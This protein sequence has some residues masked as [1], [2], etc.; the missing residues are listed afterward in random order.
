MFDGAAAAVVETVV[1]DDP[2]APDVHDVDAIAI[3]RVTTAELTMHVHVLGQ[4]HR[5]TPDLV[6][7]SCGVPFD[8]MF[9]SKRRE[10]L[11]ERETNGAPAGRLCPLCFT[12]HEIRRA[13]AADLAA[14]KAEEEAAELRE[15]RAAFPTAT[16]RYRRNTNRGD[17]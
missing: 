15:T 6:E 3:P 16:A 13:I 1:V 12:S 4:W 11:T 9:T 7:T 8:T 2:D 5:Q 10:V 17:R 14:L